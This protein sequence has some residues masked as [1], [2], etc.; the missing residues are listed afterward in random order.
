MT[1]THHRPAT[2][3]AVIEPDW[4]DAPRPCRNCGH[5]LDVPIHAPDLCAA[6]ATGTA[7]CPHCRGFGETYHA[8]GHESDVCLTCF[9]TG[10]VRKAVTA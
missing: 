5:L 3:P 4:L 10:R 6:C 9:G 1:T 8:Q 7:P 2:I